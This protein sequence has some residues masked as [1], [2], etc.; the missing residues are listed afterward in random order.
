MPRSKYTTGKTLKAADLTAEQTYLKRNIT[1]IKEKGTMATGNKNEIYKRYNFLVEIDGMTQVG[2]MECVGLE[3]ETSVIEYRE[4]GDPNPVRK[5][6][7]LTLY[8]NIILRRGVTNTAELYT[9]R[10]SVVDGKIERRSGA[11]I[12]LNDQH[13][14]VARWKFNQGWPC[15]MSGP[16]LNATENEV[17]IEELEI[18]HEGFER[19]L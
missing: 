16:D 19:V 4:G 1:E 10:K 3:A 14:E 6:P 5:L 12:L 2:F 15:F 13:E 17:A 9:W 7:G 11:I 18:C 8:S